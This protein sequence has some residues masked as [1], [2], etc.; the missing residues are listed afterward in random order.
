MRKHPESSSSAVHVSPA[1]KM[2]P[3]IDAICL[4]YS[5]LVRTRSVSTGQT[6]AVVDEQMRRKSGGRSA[7]THTQA[8]LIIRSRRSE[9]RLRRLLS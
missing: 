5:V 3:Q 2:R 9:Q 4:R 8:G 7:R 1:E 6:Y